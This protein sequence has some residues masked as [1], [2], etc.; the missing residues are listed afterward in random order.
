MKTLL[1]SAI[2]LLMI[3]SCKTKEKTAGT[4]SGEQALSTVSFSMEKTACFGRCPVYTL[5]IN[6]A[7]HKATY[8]GTQNVDKTGTHQKDI[9]DETLKSLK[10][11]FDKAKFMEMKDEYNKPQVTDLPSTY[12]SYTDAG[13]TKKIRDRYEAPVELKNLE[14]LLEEIGN[15][16]GWTKTGGE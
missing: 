3:T 10:D 11:A 16:E 5:T 7:T 13:K 15:S 1:Y 12:V 2:V 9:S 8:V 6:G 4:P 14:K